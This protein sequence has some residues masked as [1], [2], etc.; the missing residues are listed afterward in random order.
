MKR[1]VGFLTRREYDG[2]KNVHRFIL[3]W[4][5][6]KLQGSLVHTYVT[7]CKDGVECVREMER[8]GTVIV[9]YSEYK[10]KY[11]DRIFD[12]IILP[13]NEYMYLYDFKCSTEKCLYDW[14]AL[15]VGFL[16]FFLF[17]IKLNYTTRKRRS[18]A[19]DSMIM[20]NYI[21]NE[22]DIDYEYMYPLKLYHTL[23][24]IINNKYKQNDIST[25]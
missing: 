4:I 24:Q 22:K 16:L 10:E 12:E 17:N 3:S 21:L 25:Q 7:F 15:F 19:E 9:P 23:V 20:A 1:R 11:K 13:V 14:F 2:L 6:C 18:C 8:Y 5:I